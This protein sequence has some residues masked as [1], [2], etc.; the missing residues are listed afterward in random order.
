VDTERYLASNEALWDEWSAIHERSE[1]YDL[2]AIREGACHLGRFELDEVGDVQGKTLL[3]LMCQIGTDTVCW[4]R[5]GATAV[6][7]D[8]SAKAVEIASRLAADLQVDATF[9]Q[10]DVLALPDT[11]PPR[12]FDIVYT[13]RG[14]LRWLPDLGRWAQVIAQYLSPGGFFYLAE[15]HPV[16]QALNV[17][18]KDPVPIADG[19]YFERP[20]PLTREVHGS[21][22]D[23]TAQASSTAMHQWPHSMGEIITALS[24][25]GLHVEFLHEYRWADRP[26]PF[27][28]PGEDAR[29]W[30]YPPDA[31]GELPLFFS[32][33]AVPR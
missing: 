22:A 26:F 20:A 24:T 25:A 19:R 10:A 27:L 32:L 21:Y 7:V 13:S 28:R 30:V 17:N 5:R 29:T 15:I 23:P 16:A 4:A 31:A 14:V 8:F 6:G 11:L 3:H 2:Q 9:L 18:A 33:K 1:W 12:P